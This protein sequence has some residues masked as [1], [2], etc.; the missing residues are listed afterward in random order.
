MRYSGS[1]L[2]HPESLGEFLRHVDDGMKK[3]NVRSYCEYH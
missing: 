1:C 3:Q 2:E